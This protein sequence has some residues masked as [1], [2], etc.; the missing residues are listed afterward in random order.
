MMPVVTVVATVIVAPTV[1]IVAIMGTIVMGLA[2]IVPA[3]PIVMMIVPT[4]RIAECN[5]AEINGKACGR[6]WSTDGARSAGQPGDHNGAFQQ[7]L[8]VSVSFVSSDNSRSNSTRA[9]K[10]HR[11]RLKTHEQIFLSQ[12]F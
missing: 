10:G 11:V 6:S 12:I 4:V 9:P 8:H 1:I 3:M 5:V 2:G 7:L